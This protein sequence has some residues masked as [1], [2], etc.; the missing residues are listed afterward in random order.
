MIE[1]KDVSATYAVNLKNLI[2]TKGCTYE[3]LGN[4]VGVSQ[5]RISQLAKGDTLP[6]LFLAIQIAD[7]FN[8]TVSEMIGEVDADR[9]ENSRCRLDDLPSPAPVIDGKELDS[10]KYLHDKGTIGDK[11][12]YEYIEDKLKEIVR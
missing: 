12:Y 1:K 9:Y 11:Q 8:T 6:T 7:L 10:M 2:S 4:L 3:E 5:G